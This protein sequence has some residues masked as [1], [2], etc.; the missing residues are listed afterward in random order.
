MCLVDETFT[1]LFQKT[2]DHHQTLIAEAKV[3]PEMHRLLTTHI[4][5]AAVMERA[6]AALTNIALN[7]RTNGLINT[8]KSW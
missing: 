8:L 7:G 3:I 4:D 1:Y 6:C 5:L 2:K